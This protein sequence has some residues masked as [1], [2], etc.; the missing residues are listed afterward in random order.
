[1]AR[2]WANDK[3][4]NGAKSLRYQYELIPVRVL[5]KLLFCLLELKAPTD[6]ICSYGGGSGYTPAKLIYLAKLTLVTLVVGVW[7]EA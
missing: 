5:Q 4:A 1:M 2:D 6:S 7:A 3:R